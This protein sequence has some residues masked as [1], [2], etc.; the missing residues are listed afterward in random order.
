MLKGIKIKNFALFKDFKIG[1]QSEQLQQV[2]QKQEIERFPALGV[3][4]VFIGQNASGKTTF[5]E[6]LRFLADTISR[7]VQTA[8]NQSKQSS[9]AELVYHHEPADRDIHFTLLY[10]YAPDSWLEYQLI[11]SSDVHHR[12]HIACEKVIKLSLKRQELQTEILLQL[13]NGQGVIFDQQKEEEISLT[14][15]KISALNIYGHQKKYRECVW[16]YNQLVRFYLVDF[17]NVPRKIMQDNKIGGQKHLNEQFSNVQNVLLYLKKENKQEFNHLQKRLNIHLNSH[18]HLNL[19]KLHLIDNSAQMKLLLAFL[20]LS[21]PRPLIAF[22]NPDIGLH[23]DMT[24]TLAQELR[25]YSLRNDHAQVFLST[26]NVNMLENFA[27]HEVW[28]FDRIQNEQGLDE[29]HTRLISDDA[30]VRA[31]YEQGIGLSSLWYSGYL[32]NE[33]E[34]DS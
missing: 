32:D 26:H 19:E 25:D 10:E 15:K 33:R 13:E 20:I 2:S 29:I 6:A 24:D 7:N 12:P 5:F 28:S 31:M 9:F 22:D 30:V 16:L 34:Y 23:Y 27:P 11:I 17:K 4:N 14:E 8:C 18:N 21:D 1:L 3:L